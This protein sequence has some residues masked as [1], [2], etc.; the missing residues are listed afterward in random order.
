MK[1]TK[2]ATLKVRLVNSHQ[3]SGEVTGLSSRGMQWVEPLLF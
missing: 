3:K 1:N 2:K